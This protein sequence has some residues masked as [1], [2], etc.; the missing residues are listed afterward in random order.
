MMT[1]EQAR[2]MNRLRQ[3]LKME[4]D[5]NASLAAK[6]AEAQ[7]TIRCQNLALAYYNAPFTLTQILDAKISGFGNDADDVPC[8]FF[9]IDVPNAPGAVRWAMPSNEFTVRNLAGKGLLGSDAVVKL[10]Y[11]YDED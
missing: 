5:K 1:D 11:A 6:L 4:Q 8:V 3:Q 2:E 9:E 10:S 7:E